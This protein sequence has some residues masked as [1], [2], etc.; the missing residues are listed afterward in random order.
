MA[1]LE[2]HC[3]VDEWGRIT[4]PMPYRRRIGDESTLILN[5]E[6]TYIAGGSLKMLGPLPADE[7]KIKNYIGNISEIPLDS[8]GRITIPAKLRQ[9]ADVKNLVVFLAKD[10]YFELWGEE[11]WKLEVSQAKLEAKRLSAE[12]GLD[13]R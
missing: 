8:R 13:I 7:S 1:L 6:E 5:P 12:H 10:E 11:N 4:V 9:H 3:K 2:C